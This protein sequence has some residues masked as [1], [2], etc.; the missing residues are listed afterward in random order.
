MMSHF[1]LYCIASMGNSYLL[2]IFLY[3]STLFS[4]LKIGQNF[5]YENPKYNS[6]LFES[7]CLLPL[8]R[9]QIIATILKI[10]NDHKTDKIFFVIALM[11]A[12]ANFHQK[13]QMGIM[14]HMNSI[15]DC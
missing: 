9:Q 8:I 3:L 2:M 4:S 15:K 12:Y 6:D 14:N 5:L 10:S 1:F 13:G 7:T 11:T